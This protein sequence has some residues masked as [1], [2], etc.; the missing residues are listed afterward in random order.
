M[1]NQYNYY[2]PEN[3]NGQSDYTQNTNYDSNNNSYNE[4]PKKKN[5]NVKKI[6]MAVAIAVLLGGVGGAAF[7]GTSYLAGKLLGNDKEN[8][9]ES[10]K[11]VGNAQLVTSK[12]SVSSDL[13]DIVQNTLPSIVSITNMSVQQVRNFFGGIIE[14]PSESA[15]SGIVIGQN[16]KELLMVTNYHVIEGGDTIT[17]TF[18]NATSVE[19]KIKGT[20]A[21][22]D[23][24]VVAVAL[25]DIPKETM[26]YVKVATLGDSNELK[27]GE[28][29][30]AIGN[31]LG[32]GQSVT[33]GII[34]ATNRTMDGFEGEY[35]QTDAA[36]NPGNSGGALLN[37]N[38]EVI[39]INSVKI[40][41]TPVE[42]MGFAIPITDARD[43]IQVLMNKETRSK[44]SE[45]ERGYLGIVPYDVTAEVVEM[46]DMPKGVYV[47]EVLENSG[48][49]EA[50]ITKGSVITKMDGSTINSTVTLQEHLA[51]YKAGEK[52]SVVLQ[53]PGDK[54]KYK[55][56]EV[57]VVLKKKAN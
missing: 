16:D 15:G 52:V 44:V 18:G 24:A 1:D 6:A 26:D 46:Y 42:G 35:I 17:V 31:A 11:P 33:S 50:G 25:E 38:G 10:T 40:N 2:K 37:I 3:E 30:I 28:P 49:A 57:E 9:I 39:G 56:K 55:E 32:Y 45:A 41:S 21:A 19:A 34:S 5:K 48:A 7:Q 36:I 14:T 29:A 4:P 27:V 23:I 8:K 54:G 13:S 22:R 47:S 53:V 20:D 51:Y 12:T 43:I